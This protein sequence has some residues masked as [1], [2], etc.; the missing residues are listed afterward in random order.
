MFS[1]WPRT[2]QAQAD[3]FQRGPKRARSPLFAKRIQ[4]AATKKVQTQPS[5]FELE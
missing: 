4:Q 2:Q 1:L 5:C 3:T